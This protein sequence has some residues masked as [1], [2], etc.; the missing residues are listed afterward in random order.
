MKKSESDGFRQLGIALFII[1][2]ILLLICLGGYF[3]LARQGS[4]AEPGQ[5]LA[6]YLGLAGGA[7]FLLAAAAWMILRRQAQIEALELEIEQKALET[8]ERERRLQQDDT[9]RQRLEKTLERG[10]R[11]WEAIF[12]AVED[13][14]LVTDGEGK[15]I[16]SNFSATQKLVTNFNALIGAYASNVV[17]GEHNGRLVRLSDASGEA[18]YLQRP[19]WFEITRYPLNLEDEGLSQITILHD[20]SE[21]RRVENLIR[22]QNEFLETLILNSPVAILTTG[23]DQAIQSINPAFETMFDISSQEA[24]GSQ[25]DR[26]LVSEAQRPE[27]EALLNRVRNGE[28]ARQIA[29]RTRKDGTLIDVEIAVVPLMVEGWLSGALWIYHDITELIQARIAAEQADRA[30]SE[31]LANISH[32]IRTPMNGIIGMIDLTLGTELT[33]EQHELLIGAHGSASALMSILNSVLDLS[34]IEAGQFKLDNEPF[35][36]PQLIE[37]VIQALANPADKKGLELLGYV[38]PLTPRMVRG[39][40]ARLRQVL[41]N[42]VENAIKFTERGEV[43]A[44]VDLRGENGRYSTIR[45]SIIDTGIGIPADRLESIFQRFVQGD[46]SNTRRYGGTGLGLSISKELVELMGGTIVVESTPAEGSSFTFCLNLEKVENPPQT[47]P[48][49]PYIADGVRALLVDAN[50]TSRAILSRI[51]L[52]MGCTVTAIENESDIVSMLIRGHLTQSPFRLVLLDQK[53]LQHGG[54]QVLEE[55]RRDP[56]TR[57][58][59]VILMVAPGR[60]SDGL[61]SEEKACSGSLLK[62]IRQSQLRELFSNLAND[63]KEQAPAA[64]PVEAAPVPAQDILVVEDNEINQRMISTLLTRKGHRV[65]LASSGLAAISAFSA[66]PFDLIFMDVQMPGMDGLEACRR[67]RQFEAGQK[68]TPIVAMT[69]YAMQDDVENCLEAG[70]DDFISKPIDPRLVFQVIERCARGVFRPLASRARLEPQ[71]NLNR[72]PDLLDVATALGR[73]GNDAATYISLMVEFMESLPA[74]LDEIQDLLDDRDWGG[75][76]HHAHNMKG[77]AANLGAMQLSEFATQLDKASNNA[78]AEK[79]EAILKEMLSNLPLL[80]EAV[81][82]LSMDDNHELEK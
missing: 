71:A 63:P 26:I 3:Y 14:I 40:A 67:I 29:T 12:D 44:L 70:M 52:D 37:G 66:Q 43:Q 68:H 7:L 18:A 9:E 48:E 15:V 10:K 49:L 17:I 50:A 1:W 46:G 58:T 22:E 59:C 72:E 64:R 56:L 16:R 62:P 11:E 8:S 28:R 21:R 75:L 4:P 47:A 65:H 51:L 82:R 74:R 55:I 73:F 57:G 30:K 35:N 77:L 53:L 5:I 27:A 33:G 80:D 6:A 60:S 20:V 79:V 25:I 76:S 32:E 54:D 42:L 31:F 2:S 38:D 41:I 36:L 24:I 81:A 13:A 23:F 39:D 78:Q 69:A 61:H 45:F 34:K 19:G